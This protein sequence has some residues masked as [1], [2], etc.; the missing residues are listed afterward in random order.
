MARCIEMQEE[1][2]KNWLGKKYFTA[3]DTTRILGR[4]DFAVALKSK[5]S[6]D[7]LL[8]SSEESQ[9]LY[10]AEAKR[11][12]QDILNA[13]VQLIITIGKERTFE[14]YLQPDYLGA[15][16]AEEIAF[17]EYYEVEPLFTQSDFN[18]T[19]APSDHT[20]PEFQKV[21]ALLSERETSKKLVRFHYASDD[22]EL[23]SFI[24]ANFQPDRQATKQFEV[25]KNNFTHVYHKWLKEVKPS[26]N[27]AWSSMAKKGIIEADFF[28]AD[29]LSDSNKTISD[30]LYVVLETNKYEVGKNYQDGGLFSV[31]HE[32]NDKQKAHTQFW[33]RY[34]R[35]PRE[36]FWDYIITRR[37]LLVPSDVRE[38]KGSFFTPQQWVEQSQEAIAQVLGEE[39]QDTY[40]VW[41]CC[42]GTGNLLE[43]LLNKEHIFAS[44]LDEADVRVM[45]EMVVRMD[46][47][48]EE[49]RKNRSGGA[50]IVDKTH[51]GSHLKNDH[52]FQF[53]F[54][55]DDLQSEKVPAK[56]RDILADPEERKKLVIYINP[57][58]VEAGNAK[59]KS[60]TGQNRAGVATSNKT[61]E[62]Y[63]KEMGNAS[64]ELFAQ[65]L[66]RIYKEIP[67]AKIANFSK[68]KNLQGSNFQKFR[69]AFRA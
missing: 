57:P 44:T 21:K 61:Y 56:L 15:F 43:G 41:D 13:L 3:F 34:K 11:G 36:E 27:A 51:M 46:T 14:N 42:A 10:W 20:T 18:W 2:L 48:V 19:V 23:K 12:T 54:L 32:F 24:K 63:K 47:Q 67:D 6:K 7:A 17:V 69:A 4:V 60:A 62:K 66:Y 30:K 45:R 64:N 53:D 39:W 5:P 28:L 35:P 50:T 22:K 68:L 8:Q 52:I 55:N 58:Y 40:Y 65:F 59:Q 1:E 25:T 9:F 49:A 38:I 16:N 31:A 29:L 33:N 26:I 37:D